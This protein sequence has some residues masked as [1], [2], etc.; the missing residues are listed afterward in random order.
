MPQLQ[1]AV[2]V[3]ERQMNQEYRKFRHLEFDNQA[4][5]SGIEVMELLAVN[6]R[7]RH[8]GVSLLAHDRQDLVD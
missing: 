8:K 4:L 2:P 3:L 1:V 6:A 5:D 7:G